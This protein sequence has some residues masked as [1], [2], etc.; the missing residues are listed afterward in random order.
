[1]GFSH[2]LFGELP[3]RGKNT[4]IELQ[5]TKQ[6]GKSLTESKLSDDQVVTVNDDDTLTI[7]ATV[8]LTSQLV[9][10][11]RGFGS[12]LLDAHPELL[13]RAVLDNSANNATDNKPD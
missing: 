13:Y 2:P 11:L 7:K 8:N 1:M 10:W 4:A 3:E 12:G 5:F 9:W 6:A